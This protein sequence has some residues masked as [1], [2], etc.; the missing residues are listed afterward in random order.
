M[1]TIFLPAYYA[2]HYIEV[3]VIRHHVCIDDPE[4]WLVLFAQVYRIFVNSWILK[5]K[6]LFQILS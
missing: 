4:C 1:F 5:I 3:G 2:Y 6:N